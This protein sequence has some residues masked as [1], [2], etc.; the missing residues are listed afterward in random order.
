MA[1]E[2]PY[3]KFEPSEWLEGEIQVC[4]DTSI[5]CF[6]N[7]CS[8]YWLKLGEI[9]YVFA[10]HKYFRKDASVLQEL[11]NNK[12]IS[13][14]DDKIYIS[15]LDKQL[16]EFKGIS[17]KRTEAANKRWG[18]KGKDAIALQLEYKGNAI[19]EEEIRE[20]EIKKEIITIDSRKLKFA[21]TLKPFID[22][23]GKDMIRNFYEYWTEP[24]KSN[25][26]FKQEMQK[27]W[28]TERRL[29]T[30]ST[31]NYNKKPQTNEEL[32]NLTTEIRNNNPR[33]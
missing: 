25:T 18:N 30:W 27:T 9:N 26:K 20:E 3:F 33:I 31:N 32:N 10:L 12:I 21:H 13:L 11:I 19:R 7:L 5:V 24:N 6:V 4:S 8:G 28:S 2:L 1:K 17:E 15:F 29:K 16:N 23:Y 14:I 22:L